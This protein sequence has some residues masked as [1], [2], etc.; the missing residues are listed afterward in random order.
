MTEYYNFIAIVDRNYYFYITLIVV[1]LS[2][3]RV[4]NEQSIRQFIAFY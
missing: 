4:N 2:K 3:A 1:A